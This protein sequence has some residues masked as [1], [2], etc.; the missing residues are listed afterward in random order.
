MA[1]VH[2]G[3][4]PR[5]APF[6]EGDLLDE[7]FL[8][9]LPLS[10]AH[11]PSAEPIPIGDFG[12]LTTLA[13]LQHRISAIFAERLFHLLPAPGAAVGAEERRDGVWAAAGREK[14]EA[15]QDD[16]SLDV[17][18]HSEESWRAMWAAAFP[19][20]T[21]DVKTEVIPR[22]SNPGSSNL[23][24]SVSY[25]STDRQDTMME[26]DTEA[27]QSESDFLSFSPNRVRVRVASP[28][29]IRAFFIY[30]ARPGSESGYAGLRGRGVD[31]QLYSWVVY[32][33]LGCLVAALMVD[34]G[35]GVAR[36]GGLVQSVVST[37]PRLSA[38]FASPSVI[39]SAIL[40]L[41]SRFP[42]LCRP[43]LLSLDG[44]NATIKAKAPAKREG[45]RRPAR[46]HVLY[47]SYPYPA[48]ILQSP[49]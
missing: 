28:S 14:F 4:P 43:A 47:R 46:L 40:L 48:R 20:R 29:L 21:I 22:A 6:V 16:E 24:W 33:T 5:D 2:A 30:I 9:R 35:S 23:W 34:I 44:M 18:L 37:V 39:S 45:W 11:A 31:A 42:D 10:R 19:H 8:P 13:P 1:L 12:A 27:A 36:R 7:A 3:P 17:F 41:T 32:G 25:N 49:S 38:S 15:T 26:K